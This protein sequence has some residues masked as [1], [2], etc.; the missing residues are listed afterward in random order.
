M[1][2]MHPTTGRQAGRQSVAV[3]EGEEKHLI[4]R[5]RICQNFGAQNSGKKEERKR[6]GRKREREREIA[7]EKSQLN[8][9]VKKNNTYFEPDLGSYISTESRAEYI[10][11]SRSYSQARSIYLSCLHACMQLAQ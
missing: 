11:P 9:G 4:H 1:D 10:V 7:V 5:S 3:P 2:T 6:R 8:N